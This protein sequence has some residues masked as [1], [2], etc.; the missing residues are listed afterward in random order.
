MVV[1][2]CGLRPGE[3]IHTLVDGHLC[4]NHLDQAHLQF[5]REPYPLRRMELDAR[6]RRLFDF[7]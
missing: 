4:L 7:Q 3:L 5:T 1:Q 2:A 6:V